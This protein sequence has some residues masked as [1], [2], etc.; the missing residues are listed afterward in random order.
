M[1]KEKI[2]KELEKIV[3]SKN[4]IFDENELEIYNK[5][6]RGFYN[7]KSICVIFPKNKVK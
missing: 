7:Y 3:N 1:K 5:D 6:W 2:I 4:I